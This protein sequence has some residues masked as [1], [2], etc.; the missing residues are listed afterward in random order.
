MKLNQ[1]TRLS[2]FILLTILLSAGALQSDA[3][4]KIYNSVDATSYIAGEK[5][6]FIIND[7]CG[8]VN[9][10][11]PAYSTVVYESN[12][13]LIVIFDCDRVGQAVLVSATVKNCPIHNK[14]WNQYLT[15]W[16]EIIDLD[17]TLGAVT[18]PTE[19]CKNTEIEYTVSGITNADSYVWEIIPGTKAPARG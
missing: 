16:G 13:R 14:Y 2:K 5:Y 9:W 6:E 7:D 4:L 3:A 17:L 1:L 8:K 11:K 18:G 15:Y 12:K 19:V 10:F